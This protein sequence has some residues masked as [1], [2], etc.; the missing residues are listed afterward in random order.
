MKRLSALLRANP[1][2]T[3]LLGNRTPVAGW[4][5]GSVAELQIG[6]NLHPLLKTRVRIP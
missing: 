5:T 2:R 1:G 4:R 3:L 6:L